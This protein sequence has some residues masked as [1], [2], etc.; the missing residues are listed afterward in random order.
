MPFSTHTHEVVDDRDADHHFDSMLG[1]F[2]PRKNIKRR[3]G[4]WE[5]EGMIQK[6]KMTRR[7]GKGMG[8][9]EYQKKQ[10]QVGKEEILKGRGAP[11]RGDGTAP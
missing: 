3:R 1:V 11:S 9:D 7:S 2:L 10:S 4:R 8:G 6:G 5:A